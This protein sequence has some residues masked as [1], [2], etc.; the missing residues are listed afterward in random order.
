MDSPLFC[1]RSETAFEAAA[2]H[3]EMSEFAA[4]RTVATGGFLDA[5]CS[6]THIASPMSCNGVEAG[7]VVFLVLRLGAMLLV[8]EMPPPNGCGVYI[9]PKF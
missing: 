8:S 3:A 5:A 2:W 9:T 6:S 1:A 4:F 7:L